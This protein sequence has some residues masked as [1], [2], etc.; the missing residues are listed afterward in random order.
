MAKNDIASIDG[1]GPVLAEALRD[2]ALHVGRDLFASRMRTMNA[3]K[4]VSDSSR[5]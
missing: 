1:A 5:S 3:M 2:N 4:L